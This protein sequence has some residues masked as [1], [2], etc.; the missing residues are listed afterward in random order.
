MEHH[1][2]ADDSKH[3]RSVQ[4]SDLNQN[5]FSVQYCVS[6]IKDR[7]TDKHQLTED[8]TEATLFSSSKLKDLPLPDYLLSLIQSET[9]VSTWTKTSPRNSISVSL[10]EQLLLFF[11]F[12]FFNFVPA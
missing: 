10:A 3:H 5:I 9:V 4:P 11:V 7:M 1:V 6:D 2:F 8:K 12:V